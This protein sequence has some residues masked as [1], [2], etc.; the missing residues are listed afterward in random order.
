M[1]RGDI[2]FPGVA[3]QSTPHTHQPIATCGHN[4]SAISSARRGGLKR[5]P[6][7]AEVPRQTCDRLH[8]RTGIVAVRETAD[9]TAV[10]LH[11]VEWEAAQM[12]ERSW[13]SVA[14]VASVFGRSTVSVISISSR[15]A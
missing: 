11:L 13:C 4:D 14:S 8:D 12:A 7:I 3:G 15:Q 6:C 2:L 5:K 9:E 10:D 1:F